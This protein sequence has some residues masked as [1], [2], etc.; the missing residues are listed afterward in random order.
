MGVPTQ[1]DAI[2]EPRLRPRST[3]TEAEFVRWCDEDTRAEWVDGEVVVA[4][5]ATVTHVRLAKFLLQL[6]DA[7]A[8]RHALGEVLG[9]E[10]QVRLG[11]PP[12]RR[13]PD[14]LFISSERLGILT[15]THVEGAP[16]LA[17][18]IVSSDS[19]ARDWRDKYVEY[20]AAGVREYWV[21]DPMAQHME[22]YAL[23]PGQ[24][25]RQIPETEGTIYSTILPGFYVKPAWLWQ[26]P[27][28]RVS[29]L[30]EELGPA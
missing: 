13:V 25:Y 16:D 8:V 6:I 26:N 24:R 10:L 12:R 21:I 23:E 19:V 20:E 4:S 11:S 27:L 28:P 29:E 7:F 2:A 9:P 1:P 30:M 14:L 17:V 18:E 22:A 3:M 15:P 5:P